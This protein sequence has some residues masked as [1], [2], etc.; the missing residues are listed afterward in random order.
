MKDKSSLTEN[1][2]NFL[3]IVEKKSGS[4]AIIIS[5]I[6]AY[7]LGILYLSLFSI[8]TLSYFK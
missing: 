8:S 4:I 2:T 7:C 3:Q 6:S 1:V 5:L